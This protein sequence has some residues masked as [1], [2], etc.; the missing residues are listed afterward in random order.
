[1]PVAFVLALT[2]VAT[3]TNHMSHV[4][5]RG[6][7]DSSSKQTS[8]EFASNPWLNL[9][10]FL[11]KA[12]KL[13]RGMNDEALG[14]Q[15]YAEEDTAAVRPLSRSEAESW[16]RAVVLFA[17]DVLPERLQID[18]LVINVN[19]V[20]ARTGP[21][22]DIEGTTLH[23]VLRRVL[24]DVMPIYRSA[25][26]PRHD[27]RNEHWI[28]SMQ[29]ALNGREACLVRRAE[30]VFRAPWP[31][32]PIHVDA[33]V[34]AN[35]FGAYSTRPP[36]HIT[37]SA[38]ARGT[39]GNYGLEVLLHETVHSMLGPLDSALSHEAA[40]QH[41]PL[42]AELSHLVLFYTAGA[43]IQEQEP[44]Y[45]PFAESFGIWRRNGDSRT[46][47]DMIAQEWQPYLAGTRPFDLAVASIVRRLE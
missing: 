12:A 29:T 19:N 46:Y 47:R 6:C 39:Q 41:K 43:L 31:R 27:R 11:V 1:M 17:H 24:R 40:R 21:N 34:Y 32:A 15:G 36:T 16:N 9:Y 13:E 44:S 4:S 18:S 28:W 5:S 22:D 3:S 30:S 37:V 26:W 14:A 45:I 33:T 25:W 2:F 23:P 7:I 38:N 20:L 42:P 10:N 35:W 8:F